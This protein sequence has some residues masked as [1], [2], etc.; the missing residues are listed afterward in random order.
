MEKSQVRRSFGAVCGR[1][2]CSTVWKIP[3]SELVALIVPVKAPTTRIQKSLVIAKSRP[4]TAISTAIVWI[5]RRRPYRSATSDQRT[6]MS[7]EPAI[8]AVKISPIWIFDMPSWS[9]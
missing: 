9:R 3:T 8:A 5:V 6:V 4:P 2:A 7:A 1:M